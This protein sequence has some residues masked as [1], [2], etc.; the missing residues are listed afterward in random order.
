MTEQLI[1]L[2][3]LLVEREDCDAGTVQQLRN[4]L[5]Q[6]G[7]QFRALRDVT[8]ALQKKLEG[9]APAV[10]KKIHLKLGI[11]YF[12]LG[13]TVQSAEHLK[14]AKGTLARFQLA[15]VNDLAGEDRV[16]IG[17]YEGC[18]KHPPV[19]VHTLMNLGVLYEDNDQYDKAVDC[20]R[21]VLHADL[22]DDRPEWKAS[23]AE[24]TER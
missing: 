6:G 1:D 15:Q 8:Q 16:A 2:K 12:F 5:A 13:Y 18:L 21:R 10:A 24:L 23:S 19:H 22:R 3:A 14:K 11:A 9:A 17:L 4:G 7:T 20:F